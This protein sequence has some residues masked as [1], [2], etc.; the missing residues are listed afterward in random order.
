MPDPRLEAYARLLVERCIDP[1]P[2]WHVLVATTTEARPLAEVRPQ[3]ESLFG[4]QAM[5]AWAANKGGHAG[6]RGQ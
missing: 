6:A 5:R 1:Q 4:R 3:I 2:G